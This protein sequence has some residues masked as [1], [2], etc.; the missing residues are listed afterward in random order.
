MNTMSA[1]K[2]SR[3]SSNCS[4]THWTL[5]TGLQGQHQDKIHQPKK[6]EMVY[7]LERQQTLVDNRVSG[8]LLGMCMKNFY[9]GFSF[10][11]GHWGLSRS[12]LG[13]K[14]CWRSQQCSVNHWNRSH[15]AVSGPRWSSRALGNSV[16]NIQSLWH[17]AGN[18]LS[19][20]TRSSS[21]CSFAFSPAK[22][23]YLR[24]ITKA[25]KSSSK[26]FGL[27]SS[28]YTWTG[29]Q[30]SASMLLMLLDP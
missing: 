11:K 23:S 2:Q 19:S 18:H 22:S 15:G 3:Y 5:V 8:E 25:F 12:V 21:E 24:Q 9:Q 10:L 14:M 29:L 30:W 4:N 1:F 13:W 6:L 7:G 26:T 16:K 28:F 20:S 27:S 17:Y